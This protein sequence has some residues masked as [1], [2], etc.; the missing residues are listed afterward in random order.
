MIEV[1]RAK[2][3]QKADI[4]TELDDAALTSIISE[5]IV[6][7]AH[8]H[9]IS[10]AQ[11]DTLRQQIFASIRGLDVLEPLIADPEIT[12]I[13]VNGYDRIFYE[14]AGALH[15]YPHSFS[16]PDKLDNIIQQIAA[17][18]NKRINQLCPI[19]DTYL[20]DGSRVNVVVNP[21]SLGSS[22]ITIRKFGNKRLTMEA[23]LRYGA[24]DQ[25]TC[26]LLR[27]LV[28]SGHNIFL[29]GGTSSGKTTFLNALSHFIPDDQRVITI[30]DSPEL[31][32]AAS[33]CVRLVT[34]AANSE[35]IGQISL[36]DLIKAALRMR[37]DRIVVGEIR[38]SEAIDMLN[39][40]NTGHNGC[41]STAHANSTED[42][43]TRLEAMVLS[44][45]HI[46][47][48]AIRSMICS[49]I[50]I[51]VYLGR[52]PDKS[53]RLMSI[54]QLIGYK[55]DKYIL[56][57]VCHR[58]VT[59]GQLVYSPVPLLDTYKLQEYGLMDDYRLLFST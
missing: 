52:L 34:R 27:L 19:V 3:L 38:G 14:K 5:A 56:H 59:T 20:K 57:P 23:L 12:E 25:L 21:I 33:N 40:M 1:I 18:S 37:P 41:L 2:V 50:D 44:G 24:I 7:E 51:F 22:T 55:D 6:E 4:S 8:N 53:R 58:D 16:S 42:M 49:A 54:S 39:S 45:Q 31:N 26:D 43:L 47:L 15:P 9:Y 13:M 48:Q 17:Y 36:S 11:R 32:I 10:L 28:I 29:C 30:E 46:P 35:G